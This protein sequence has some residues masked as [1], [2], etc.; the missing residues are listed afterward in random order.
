MKLL[1]VE[2]L[3]SLTS[4][5]EATLLPAPKDSIGAQILKKMGW[6]LGHGIGPK[7]TYEQRKRENTLSHTPTRSIHDVPEVDDHEEAKKHLYPRRDTKPLIYKKKD[8]VHGIGYTPGM[9]LN[10]MIATESG[11]LSNKKSLGPNIS[12]TTYLSFFIMSMLIIIIQLDLDWV[13]LTRQMKMI[14]M[15]MIKPLTQV[16]VGL[17]MTKTRTMS[18]SL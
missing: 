13:L 1:I 15:Y 6:R 3:S 2:L 11:A 8:N 9:G 12:G 7:L 16:V 18:E 5:L 14:S 17:H 4:V 10:E